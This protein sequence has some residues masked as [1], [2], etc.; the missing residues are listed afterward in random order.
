MAGVFQTKALPGVLRRPNRVTIER[1]SEGAPSATLSTSAVVTALN[2]SVPALVDRAEAGTEQFDVEGV[3][4]TQNT[5]LFLDGIPTTSGPGTT[6]TQNGI[7]Y[8]VAGNGQ[9][10]YPDAAP[11]DRVT[12]ED[13]S[14]YLV[15]SVSRY[16][17]T[18]SLQAHMA[19]GRAW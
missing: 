3:L 13:G 6:V 1:K 4:Y 17:V 16:V 14:T 10:A 18:R 5:M 8:L 2:T 9:C 11:G 12:D 7:A 19:R 15:L